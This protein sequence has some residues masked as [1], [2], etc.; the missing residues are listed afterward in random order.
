MLAQRF[1]LSELTFLVLTYNRP[2]MVQRL[3][4]YLQAQA[5]E[6]SLVLVDH[7]DMQSQE[8]NAS[9]VALISP[10]IKHLCLPLETSLQKVLIEAS[11]A[12]TTKYSAF[13]PDDDIPIIDGVI[14]ALLM[15][16]T[17]PLVVCAQGYVLSFTETDSATCFGPIEDFVPGY[18]DEVPLK[19]L[20]SMI[21]RY[22]LVFWGLYRTE[23]L[24]WSVREFAAA[25]ISNLMFQ[26]FFFAALVC[27]RGVIERIQSIYLWR[28][29]DASIVDRR[30]V[31]AYH[32]LV[33]N[34]SKFGAEYCEFRDNLIPY[35]SAEMKTNIPINRAYVSR[36]LDLIFVQFLVR[37]INY[38]EL[39]GH[40]QMFLAEPNKNYF[41]SLAAHKPSFNIENFTTFAHH[42]DNNILID[43]GLLEEVTNIDFERL[44]GG[45]SNVIE[46]NISTQMLIDA[47]KSALAY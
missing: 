28:R 41:S 9:A 21:R 11:D 14:D 42:L 22:Q 43:K 6:I 31:H 27:S 33:D 45:V 37:H 8:S 32:Q 17:N 24:T 40:I 44:R 20:F 19:R 18:N 16:S 5:P 1:N 46:R 10:S 23:I 36:I 25:N 4:R 15:L 30:N 2:E 12:I 3:L 34:P 13:C 47:V 35:Y 7:G 39:D 26:E 29:T 38:S